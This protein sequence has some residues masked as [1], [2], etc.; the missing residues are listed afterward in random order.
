[1][2]NRGNIIIYSEFDFNFSQVINSLKECVVADLIMISRDF[3]LE[4]VVKSMPIEMLIVNLT[5]HTIDKDLIN[6]M[7]SIPG[8]STLFL[9]NRIKKVPKFDFSKKDVFLFPIEYAMDSAL[10]GMNVNSILELTTRNKQLDNNNDDEKS[11][12]ILLDKNLCRYIMEL[13]QKN[14][15]LSLVKAKIDQLCAIASNRVQYGLRSISSSINSTSL[16]SKYWEDFNIYFEKI[17]PH[18]IKI[19]SMKHPNLTTKDL[20]YCCYLKMNMSNNDIKNLLSINQESV[21][22]HKYRLKKKLGLTRD[23]SIRSYLQFDKI[24]P[25][26]VS[27]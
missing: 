25:S 1:M 22:T 13:D 26:L 19:L 23:Q 2:K 16:Q 17:N 20:K 5:S 18:F 24:N 27:A 8:T 9:T 7:M 6:K 4:A 3:E 10:L 14:K 11:D 15:T 21:R 12:S